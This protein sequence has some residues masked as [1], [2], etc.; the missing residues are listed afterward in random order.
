MLGLVIA[1]VVLAASAHDNAFG[2]A[3]LDKVAAET[4]T[5][6]K[7]L[8]DQRFKNTV[9]DHGEQVGMAG[10]SA[11]TTACAGWS[12][13]GPNR[14]GIPRGSTPTGTSPAPV[15][16]YAGHGLDAGG[17]TGQQQARSLHGLRHEDSSSALVSGL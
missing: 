6:Q 8:V 16:K 15:C 10:W 3:L 13:Y 14:A 1:V 17:P 5:V 12:E 2:T 9:V 7:A 4:D 11:S